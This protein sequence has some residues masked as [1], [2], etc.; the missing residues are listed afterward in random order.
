MDLKE[1]IISKNLN[2]YETMQYDILFLHPPSSFKKQEVPLSGIFPTGIGKSDLF[3]NA[4]IGVNALYH[5]LKNRGFNPGFLNLGR[6]FHKAV[7]RGEGFDLVRIIEGWSAKGF[8]IDLHWAVHIPGALDLAAAIKKVFPESFIFLGGLTATYFYHEILKD[9]PFINAVVLGEADEAI[10]LLGEAL[11][12]NSSQPNLEKVPSLAH[13]S[14][15]SGH[16]SVNPIRVPKKWENVSFQDVEDELSHAYISIKGCSQDCLFCG[17]SNFSYKNFFFREQPITLEPGQLIQELETFEKN[18][19]NTVSLLGDIRIMGKSYVDSLFS[20]LNKKNL[21]I[22]IQQDLFFPAGSRYLERWKNATSKCSFLF[23]AESADISVLKRIGRAYTPKELRDLIKDCSSLE[24]PLGLGFLFALPGQDAD[25]I[26][27]TMDFIEQF[28]DY[29]YFDFVFEPIFYIDPGSRIFENPEM[30]GYNIDF[31]TLKD[32]KMNLEKPHW[33]QSIGYYTQWLPKKDFIDMI[34]HV[35]ERANRI[36]FNKSPKQSSLYVFNIE[37]LESNRKLIEKMQTN[38]PASETEVKKLIEEIFPRYLLK[39]NLLSKVRIPINGRLPY[40][41]FPYLSYLFTEIV[42]LPSSQLLEYLKKLFRDTYSFPK[43]ISLNKFKKVEDAPKSLKKRVT[44]IIQRHEV[45]IDPVFIDNLVDF[46]WTNELASRI[47]TIKNIEVDK[48]V[49]NLNIKD[50]LNCKL[51]LN[52]SVVLKT[53]KFN[54]DLIDWK[55]LPD[56]VPPKRTCY[57]YLTQKGRR[58]VITP[59]IQKLL[60]LCGESRNVIDVINNLK[61]TEKEEELV[62]A[63]NIKSLV[64]ERIILTQS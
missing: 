58:K 1:S 41:R 49:N 9:Y 39:D 28:V 11:K 44:D 29:P 5:Q 12:K 45:H 53:F 24:L 21:N 26:R 47:N 63:M 38:E 10:V 59:F 32:F 34:F 3:P 31:R 54:F 35:T 27:S 13:R 30:W 46:E 55:N 17:G 42:N 36:R 8:G 48:P 33:S 60:I 52:E 15:K 57:L 40:F 61:R 14:K 4:P 56:K 62:I 7:E 20:E 16:I 2:R 37:N 19:V 50:F 64:L 22:H 25:S 23:I 6:L 51:I 18:G 43:E